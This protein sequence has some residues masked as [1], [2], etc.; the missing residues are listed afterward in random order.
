L[1]DEIF[2]EHNRIGVLAIQHNPGGKNDNKF[3]ANSHENKLVYAKNKSLSKIY[4]FDL[5]EE[6]KAKYNKKDE[7]GKYLERSLK[8]DGYNSTRE[9]RP[10]LF[11][12][13]FYNENTGEISLD[14]KTGFIEI[15]PVDDNGIEGTWRRNK[16]KIERE[17]KSELVVKKIKGKYKVYTK[18]RLKDDTGRK[19]KTFW[20]DS[21]YAGVIG[22]KAIKEIF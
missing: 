1:A 8:Q 13:I 9:D 7:Y 17:R 12:P 11:F 20:Y 5:S 10:N 22:T 21:K 15:L 3:F 6:D 2:G 18:Q 14:K 4:N 16:A 19:P